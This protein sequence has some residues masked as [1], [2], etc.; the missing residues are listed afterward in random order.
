MPDASDVKYIELNKSGNAD[1]DQLLDLISLFVHDL[2]GPLVVMQSILRMTRQGRLDLNNSHHAE[3]VESG[4]IAM[5]RARSIIG[6][7]MLVSKSGKMGI[8]IRIQSVPLCELIRKSV[9]LIKPSAR[10][11]DISLELS[12]PQE[13]IQVQADPELLMRVLDNL[14]FNALRHSSLK[15]TISLIVNHTKSKAQVSICDD[16]PGFE[17][18]DPAD[19]FDKYK[20]LELRMH[21]KHRGVG[22]GLYFCHQVITAMG[23][24]IWAQ[25]NPDGGAEFNFTLN[26]KG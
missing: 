25:G 4:N 15:S 8:P 9:D 20:Q 5:E 17:G 3:L 18:F 2:E 10:E 14:L 23:G 22:L 26:I 16:G 24:K 12:L 21:G 11:N 6:D 7:L 19:L 1:I 13:E